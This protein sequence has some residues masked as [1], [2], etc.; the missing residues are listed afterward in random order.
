M[1]Y[2]EQFYDSIHSFIYVIHIQTGLFVSI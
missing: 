2:S 1:F